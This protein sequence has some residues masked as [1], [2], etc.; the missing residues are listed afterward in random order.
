[1]P[2]VVTTYDAPPLWCDAHSQTVLPTLLPRRLAG[3]GTSERL[4][5]DD[6]DFV[7]MRWLARRH[8]RLAVLSHGLEGSTEAGYMRGMAATL[9]QAGWDVVG[10]NYRGCGGVE[11]R[12]LRTYHSGE[13]DDLRAVVAQAARGYDRVV[14]VGFSLGGAIALKAAG[15]G[16]LPASLAAVVAVSAPIDLASSARR[17]D[18]VPGQPVV[19]ATI[20]AHTGGQDPGQGAAISGTGRAAGRGGRGAGGADDPGV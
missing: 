2:L 15:E 18:E 6:G 11:N 16:G 12:R 8:R 13:S 14:L 19:P 10:W 17:L 20:P 7:D 1:M 4:D 5:L 3:W 9:H